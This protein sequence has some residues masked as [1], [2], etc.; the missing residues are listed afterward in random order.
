[1]EEF[2]EV[3]QKFVCIRIETFE[4]SEAEEKVRE[5][6]NGRYA[7]TAFCIF[8]PQGER[9]LTRSGRGPASAFGGGGQRGKEIDDAAIVKQMHQI[10]ARFSPKGSSTDAILQDFH[11]FRQALNVAS[12]DQ[13]LL[14]FVDVASDEK[15]EVEANLKEV[16]AEPKITGKFHLNFMDQASDKAWAKKIQGRT[17]P[18]GIFIIRS[19]QFGLDGV[20][21]QRLSPDASVDDIKESMIAANE[22]FSSVESRKSYSQHV[23]AGRRQ[24][25]HFENEIP[26]EG[27]QGSDSQTNG[28]Q[29]RQRRK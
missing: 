3:S 20:V 23:A 26:R 7:N 15:S 18:Q 4:N 27:L 21:M 10:A 29:R 25:I 16:F 28:N 1:M 8:D 12:A 22:T 6:L 19:G 17:S 11:S 2:L 13:R 14:V 24:R 9:K 5:L